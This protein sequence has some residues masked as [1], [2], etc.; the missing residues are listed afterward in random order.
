MSKFEL[1]NPPYIACA[2]NDKDVITLNS[3]VLIPADIIE[4]RVDMFEE[5]EPK[6]VI[7]II[8]IA[9][10]KFD[11][12]KIVT[13]RDISE[14]G[15][16]NIINRLSLYE[17]VL[18]FSDIIDIEI[19]AEIF[20]DVK[21]LCERFSATLI[22]SYHNFETTPDDVFLEE[23]FKK[24]RILGADIIKI[25]VM[26]QCK[27]DILRVVEFTLRHKKDKIV[28][29]SMGDLGLPTR[30]LNP[31]VGSIITYGYINSPSAPGQLSIS[32]IDHIFRVLK[33]R[34]S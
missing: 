1:K 29:M 28:T 21:K 7:E 26:P 6:H 3:K 2:I 22:G 17:A 32:E 31:V 5:T 20:D 18:P 19:N 27:E 10:N 12:P 16:K 23:V 15:S 24:G 34:E 11:K 30:I 33:I 14:G 9:G 25:A 13:I 8:K 4:L